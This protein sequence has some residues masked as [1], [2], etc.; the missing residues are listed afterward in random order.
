[1]A[2]QRR[3][4]D[5]TQQRQ[6]PAQDQRPTSGSAAGHSAGT[7]QPAADS[8]RPD[9]GWRRRLVDR[10]QRFV[11]LVR[12]IELLLRILR[13][14]WLVWIVQPTAGQPAPA[15]RPAGSGPAGPS[16]GSRPARS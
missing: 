6:G 2:G 16:A 11:E 13:I 5:V 15:G 12:F 1:N 9:P 10:I 7:A 8:D 4:G 14:E 3:L